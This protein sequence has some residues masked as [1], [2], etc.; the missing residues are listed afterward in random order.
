MPSARA[1]AR[2]AAPATPASPFGEALAPKL[3]KLGIRNRRDLALHLPSRY[4]DETRLTPLA[5]AR[6]GMPVLVE[7]EVVEAKVQ[8]R[9]RRTLVVKLIE[10]DEELWVRFL[11]FYPVSYTHLTLPTILRV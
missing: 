7:A 10:G 2:P 11:N 8:F 4:E 1:K 5:N 9:G 6:A 3:A